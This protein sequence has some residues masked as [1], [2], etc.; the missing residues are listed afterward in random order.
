[1]KIGK[2]YSKIGNRYI[3]YELQNNNLTYK[4][5]YYCERLIELD[6]FR[7]C[8]SAKELYKIIEFNLKYLG[9]K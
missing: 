3:S 5:N 1:M 9:D 4:S 7:P 2:F 6:K 8:Y